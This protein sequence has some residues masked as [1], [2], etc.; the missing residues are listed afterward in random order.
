MG[1]TCFRPAGSERLDHR[2]LSG[3]AALSVSKGG[4]AAGAKPGAALA[5]VSEDSVDADD[6]L[7]AHA[8]GALFVS[9]AESAAPGDPGTVSSSLMDKDASVSGASGS[10][11]SSMHGRGHMIGAHAKEG[12][13]STASLSSSPTASQASSARA[14][15][16]RAGTSTMGGG[17]TLTY[18]ATGVPAG[19]SHAGLRIVAGLHRADP[20]LGESGQSWADQPAAEAAVAEA[21]PVGKQTGGHKATARFADGAFSMPFRKPKKLRQRPQQQLS[22]APADAVCNVQ[23]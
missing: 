12:G 16:M 20:D 3:A 9:D 18:D 15:P 5:V 6:C 7:A 1:N 10:V 11:T 4:V 21:E 2:E 23:P 17:D 22:S 14:R 13:A 8:A 19:L